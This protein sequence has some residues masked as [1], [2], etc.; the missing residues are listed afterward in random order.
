MTEYRTDW[1]IKEIAD[2][3][4]VTFLFNDGTWNNK[5]DNGGSDFVTTVDIWVTDNGQHFDYDPMGPQVPEVTSSLAEGTYLTSQ[6]AALDSTNASGDVIYYTTNGSDPDIN[7][8]I[9]SVAISVSSSMTLKAVARNELGEWGSIASFT[10]IINPD[11]DLDPP[12]IQANTTVG[13]HDDPVSVSFTITDNKSATTTA[14]YT[15]D[16]S[17]PTTSSSQYVSG[18]AQAGLTGPSINTTDTTTYRFLVVDGADLEASGSFYYHIGDQLARGDFREES[19]YFMITTRFFD[20]DSSN[21]RFSRYAENN[22]NL[23][24]N[25]PSFRGDFKGLIEKLDYI[26]ALG[27]SAIWITPPVLNRSDYDYHGYHAW[28]MTKIDARLESPGYTYQNLIDE[29]HARGMRVVQD[30]VLNHSSRYGLADVAPVRFW[31]DSNDPQWGDGTTID[32]YDVENPSFTYNGLDIEPISGKHQYNG[33]LWQT[34]VPNL[35]WTTDLSA[36]GT[37]TQW[38][39]PEGY[40]VWNFQWPDEL[41]VQ[42]L[43]DPDYFHGEF[44]KN[45]EDYT[46]QSGSI[47]EDCIDIDTESAVAQQYMIDAYNQYIDMGVDA[48]RIDTV[49]HISRV[50]FNRHFIPAFKERGGEN[51]YMFGEVCTKVHEVWNKGVAPLSAPFYTWKERTTYSAD[52]TAAALEGYDYENGMG[53][54]NQPSEDNHWLNGNDYHEPDYSQSSGMAVIDFPMHVNFSSAGQAWNM[55]GSDN[56]YNDP[57]WSVVYVDSHDYGPSTSLQRYGGGA[58]AW[59]ENSALMFTFRGIPCIYYGSEIEFQAGVDV[60]PNPAT[61]PLASTGR[62]YFG[63]NI[64]GSVTVTD[65]GQYSNATGAMA[66]TLSNPLAQNFMRLNRIRRAVPALQKGQ[67]STD[68]VSGGMAFKRRFTDASTGVDSFCLVTISGGATFSGIPNGTYTDCVT[69]DVQNVTGG[70]LTA[71]C[72]GQGNL[73]VYVLDLPGNPAPGKIGSDTQWIK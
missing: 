68:G 5:V 18:N 48:F 7:S 26:K 46:C 40:H 67:Y 14:Y 59:A 71:N 12:S 19:I 16:G 69:G 22:G 9:Y 23:A 33:D 70:S 38:M 1:Y 39:S 56:L 25:D 15:T 60:D 51:F 13:H 63:D 52:D 65:F 36:W 10:Y 30:M 2:T 11:A 57:T 54:G 47:H 24:N 61:T 4:S 55:R 72:S 43:F 58:T 37:K 31:G 44:L 66:N 49:K 3:S 8:P 50:M 35:P 53:T 32:Y 73:R 42:N 29:C 45:W 17:I 41:A 28:D 62:A 34:E 20:G 64:E 27:F 21:N 6:S